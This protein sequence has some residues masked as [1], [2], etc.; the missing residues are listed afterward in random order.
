VSPEDFPFLADTATHARDIP[1][2][3]EFRRGLAAVIHGLGGHAP[4]VP[5][6]RARGDNRQR[7]ATS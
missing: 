7:R 2:E 1:P 4:A 6:P 3:V 5:P